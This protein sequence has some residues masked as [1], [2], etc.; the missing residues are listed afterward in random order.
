MTTQEQKDL[1]AAIL[2]AVNESEVTNHVKI[3]ALLSVAL[4]TAQ[5]ITPFPVGELQK[6]LAYIE[7]FDG[8]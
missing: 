7:Q 1:V 5:I 6:R 8:V 3:Y 2:N 4:A